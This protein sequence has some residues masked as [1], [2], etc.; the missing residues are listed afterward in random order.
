MKV[1]HNKLQEQCS[2]HILTDVTASPLRVGGFPPSFFLQKVETKLF[3]FIIIIFKMI[4]VKLLPII[5]FIYFWNVNFQNASS[6]FISRIFWNRADSIMFVFKKRKSFWLR[7]PQKSGI[8]FFTS[9]LWS[10]WLS[11]PLVGKIQTNRQPFVMKT[12]LV[13]SLLWNV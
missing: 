4:F 9:I 5:R 8:Y 6:N 1:H 10:V 7:N 3:T 11:I 12:E 2:S 13:D